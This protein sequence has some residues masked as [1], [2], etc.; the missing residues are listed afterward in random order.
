MNGEPL[1]LPKGSI[2]AILTFVIIG[3][4]IA[5]IFVSFFFDV[6]SNMLTTLSGLSGVVLRDYFQTR[7]GN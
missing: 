1:G 3:S 7:N 2:R 6:D 4:F 5:A